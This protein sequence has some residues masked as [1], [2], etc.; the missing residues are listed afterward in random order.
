MWM[1][2]TEP[3]AVEV[4]IDTSTLERSGQNEHEAR[5]T[6]PEY[7]FVYQ[8]IYR[9][10]IHQCSHQPESHRSWLLLA[11]LKVALL[12]LCRIIVHVL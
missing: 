5:E 10:E 12:P 7:F 11:I 2:C 3:Q 4:M 9:Q 1:G 8:V 6:D